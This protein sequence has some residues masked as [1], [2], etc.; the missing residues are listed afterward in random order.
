MLKGFFKLSPPERVFEIIDTFAPLGDEEISLE[1]SFGRVLSRDMYSPSDMPGFPRATMDGYAVR[2]RDT[3]GASPHLP[4]IVQLKGEVKMGE[5]PKIRI[6]KG[7]AAKIATG[8]MLPDGADGVVMIEFCHMIDDS[9]IEIERAISPWENVMQPDDDIKRGELVL[10][11]GKRLRAQDIGALAGLGIQYVSVYKRPRVAIISTGDEVIPIDK[12][13]SPGQ[14]RDIN[15]YTLSS[16]CRAIGAH[17]IF[18][19]ICPDEFSVL[20]E[21]VE[22]GIEIA[23]SVWISGGSSVGTRD[24][25]LKVFESMKGFELLVHGIAIR[26]G[27]PTII[28][29]VD[30]KPIVGLPG[31]VSSA[32]IVAEIFMSRII[33]RLSGEDPS[34]MVPHIEAIMTRNMESSPGREDYIRVRLLKERGDIFADPIMG[35][36][37]LI[38]PLIQ[39]DGLVRIE[40]N[41]EGVY[42]GEKV[43]VIPFISKGALW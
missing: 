30:S 23:N 1:D 16:F 3:F 31:Q 5:I 38:S 28:G 10:K 26:P 20:R 42:E 2:S 22:K 41:R 27:K 25:T 6:G 19:G 33:K 29:K 24:L 32:F 15:R 39:A 12:E 43:E 13:P 11:R 9:T 36:S 40:M 18:L 21:L 17:P 8:G 4:A 7:E 35:K 37:G 34:D 14:V